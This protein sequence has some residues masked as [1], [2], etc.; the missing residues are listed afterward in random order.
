M[1]DI[2][3]QIP[4]RARRVAELGALREKAGEAFLRIQPQ[5]EYFGVTADP[6]EMKEAGAFLTHAFFVKPEELDF[7]VLGIYDLDALIIRGDFS[8]SLTAK[9][10]EKWGAALKEDGQLLL[11]MPNACYLRNY[12]EQLAG[13]G[14]ET[15]GLTATETRKIL[16]ESGFYVLMVSGSYDMEQD[17][18]LRQGEENNALLLNLQMM[19]KKL[20]GEMAQERDPWLKCLFFRAAKKALAEEEKLLIQAVIGETIVTPRVRIYEPNGFLAQEAGVTAMSITRDH[21]QGV[22]ETA[23]RFSR[24]IFIRQRLSYDTALQAFATVESLRRDGYLILAEMDDNPNIFMRD[25]LAARE[26][27]YLGTH[28]MQVS[29]KPLAEVLRV[30]NPQVAVFRNEL[31]ELPARRD[32]DEER[33]QRLAEGGE[34]VTFFFGALNRTKEWQ[35]VMPVICGAIEKYG[36]RLRF[37]V[38]SDMGFYEAL[39]TEYKEYI[40]TKDMYGGQ[41][42]PYEMYQ[43]ALH[44][45]DISFLPLSNTEFNRTKSDLKFIESAGHGAVVIASPTVYEDTVREG[46]TGFIYRS[47]AEFRQQLELLVENRQR[48]LETAEAAYEYVKRERLLANHYLE[49]L[50]WYRE[51][52]ERREE[53]DAAMVGRLRDWQVKHPEEFAE[54]GEGKA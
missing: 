24:K 17:L 51:M 44:S 52:L 43:E 12:L 39:P 38:L 30:Y 2:A 32:Y 41:F 23:A 54:K 29:T 8:T 15:H 37:K 1:I 18:E 48:R 25:G 3:A 20:G 31:K 7:E 11:E 36:P 4:P 35:E 45:S 22:N 10:L 27:S 26:L 33:L 47:P 50:A 5:A 6:A 19:L 34:Y 16:Q 46:R 42:V 21:T 40:G 9:R 14:Q 49:R 28:A 53:L 13:I